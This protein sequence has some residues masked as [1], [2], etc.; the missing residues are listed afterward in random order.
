MNTEV[1]VRLLL[2]N[3]KNIKKL[4]IDHSYNNNKGHIGSSL[5][6][7]DLCIVIYE[8]L[9][10]IGTLYNNRDRFILSKGHA[11]LA[12]YAILY[13]NK[14]IDRSTWESF[15][16]DNTPLGTHPEPTFPGIDFLTGSLGH[17]LSYGIG[18]AL[19]STFGSNWTTVVLLS[20]SELNEGSTLESIAIAGHLKV[21]NLLVVLDNNGQQATG[22]TS[23]ILNMGNIKNLFSNFNWRYIQTDGHNIPEFYKL[24]STTILNLD[25]P[26]VIDAQTISGKGISF[27]EKT[28]EWHYKSLN[29]DEHATATKEIYRL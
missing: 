17:G 25:Q 13:L 10:G 3:S 9:K 18:S 8:H 1:D 27:M 16:K 6:V 14:I 21:S 20:D 24:Y 29:R 11:A 2:E 12:W 26:T 19:G 4:I 7:V 22:R 15:G 5:S 28:I 23:E